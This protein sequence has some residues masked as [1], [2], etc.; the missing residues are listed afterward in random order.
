MLEAAAQNAIFF[1]L[2]HD[3]CVCVRAY[4]HVGLF[5]CLCMTVSNILTGQ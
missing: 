1:L 2:R 4:V 5:V 3:A